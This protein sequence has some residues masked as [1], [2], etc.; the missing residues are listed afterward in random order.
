[1]ILRTIKS[2]QLGSLRHFLFK[3]Q[4]ELTNHQRKNISKKY[5]EGPDVRGLAKVR[6]PTIHRNQ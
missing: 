1:M 6:S 3:T 4:F 5:R 2:C